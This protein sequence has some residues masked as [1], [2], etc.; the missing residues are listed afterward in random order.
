VVELGQRQHLPVA[1]EQAED[2]LDR[3]ADAL[4][5]RREHLG[6]EQLLALLERRGEQVLLGREEVVEAARIGRGLARDLGQAG[7]LVP[8]EREE[9]HGG[10]DQ[11]IAGVR[12][13]H[14][15]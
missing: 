8:L 15:S 12:G 2:A 6:E 7:A 14:G 10:E 1:R 3:I 13:G 5:D 11:S 9:L 4:P